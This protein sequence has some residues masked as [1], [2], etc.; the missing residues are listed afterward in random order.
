MQNTSYKWVV[1]VGENHFDLT[2]KQAEV[3]KEAM[4]QQQKIIWFRDFAISIPHIVY[5]ERV[6][7]DGVNGVPRI[8]SNR[9]ESCQGKGWL[10]GVF[11][12][13]NGVYEK[14]ECKQC[15]GLGITKPHSKT[16]IV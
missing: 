8:E 14:E 5:C 13:R 6:K 11:D 2:P 10:F 1:S 4:S 12:E 3:L 7:T 16:D 15:G 9:C